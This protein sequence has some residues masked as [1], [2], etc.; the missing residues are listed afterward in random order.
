MLTSL[1]RTFT[2]RRRQAFNDRGLVSMYG[3]FAN[4][5]FSKLT[6]VMDPI[7]GLID[8]IRKIKVRRIL[9][10]YHMLEWHP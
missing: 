10:W 5:G 9:S 2:E 8:A 7:K 4:V 1:E 6:R 3:E